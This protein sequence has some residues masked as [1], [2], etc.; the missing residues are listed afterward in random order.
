LVYSTSSALGPSHAPPQLHL[1][2]ISSSHTKA[3]SI[4]ISIPQGLRPSLEDSAA[5][6]FFNYFLPLTHSNPGSLFFVLPQL[7]ARAPANSTFASTI[8]A[9]GLICLANRLRVPRIMVRASKEYAK[10]LG[11]I[12]KVISDPI[13]AKEDQTVLI[14]MLLGL[15]E[16]VGG[17][18]SYQW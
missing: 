18:C 16:Q 7:Y 1:K 13:Q 2:H 5:S 12:N 11:K 4:N 17:F 6:L 14:V 3:N 15:Y 10:V 9:L 8:T